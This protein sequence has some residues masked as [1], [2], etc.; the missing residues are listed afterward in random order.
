MNWLESLLYGLISGFTRFMPI[1]SSA[2]QAIFRT[3]FGF[4]NADPLQNLLVDIA[5]LISLISGFKPYFDKI[6][7]RSSGLRNR[8]FYSNENS[9]DISLTRNALLPMLI[10][11][12]V[13]YYIVNSNTSLLLISVG[14]LFNGIILF[15]PARL[16]QGNKDGRSMSLLD[17]IIIGTASALSSIPGFSGIGCAVSSAEIRGAD[18]RKALHWAATLSVPLLV[19]KILVDFVLIFSTGGVN[20]IDFRF[21]GYLFSVIGAYIGGYIAILIISRLIS[22]RNSLSGFAYYSWGAALYSFILFLS[23]A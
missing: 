12:L 18:S 10:I 13:L 15:L 3:V 5:L 8:R 4:E 22:S 9:G 20:Y 17:S 23:I 14:L 21:F 2:H 1:S 16:L 6:R 11:S 19:I 7:N